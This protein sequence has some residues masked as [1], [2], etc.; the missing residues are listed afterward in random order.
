MTRFD[1]KDFIYRY[2]NVSNKCY[3]NCTIGVYL[4]YVNENNDNIC[5]DTYCYSQ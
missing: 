3:E 2:N 4:Y 1:G 5:I